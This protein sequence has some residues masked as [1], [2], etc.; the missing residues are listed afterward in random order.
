[1]G[2]PGPKVAIGPLRIVKADIV[3]TQHLRGPLAHIATTDHQH[4]QTPKTC[5]A[6][7]DQVHGH[8]SIRSN[9]RQSEAI[10]RL[11]TGRFLFRS[12]DSQV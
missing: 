4:A 6:G 9:L 11:F 5:R 7:T 2:W 1:M 3:G 10:K 12:F 8:K